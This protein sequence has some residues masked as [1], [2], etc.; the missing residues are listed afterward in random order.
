MTLRL[1]DSAWS[2]ELT[3]ALRA[4][5]SELRIV[6]PYIKTGALDRLLALKPKVIQVITRFNLADFAEGVSDIAALL[7]VLVAGGQ[8]RGIKNLHAK[9]YLFGG[10][11]AIAR[12][13]GEFISVGSITKHVRAI[14]LSMRFR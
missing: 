1:V 13:G 7:K 14:D 5:T 2:T 11:R 3:Q 4:D 8:V 10:S 12:A 6:C 9:L